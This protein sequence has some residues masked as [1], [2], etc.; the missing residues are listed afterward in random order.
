MEERHNTMDKGKSQN[1]PK[2]PI[3]YK[4][5]KLKI[6][7]PTLHKKLSSLTLKYFC[8]CEHWMVISFY[9]DNCF[10]AIPIGVFLFGR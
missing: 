1:N 5:Q 3:I 2:P 10:I 8:Y 6:E 9:V 4:T 7:Q